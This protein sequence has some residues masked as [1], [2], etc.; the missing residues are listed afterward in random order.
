MTNNAF[1]LIA[2]LS[3]DRQPA[4]GRSKLYRG[5]SMSSY[6]FYV[7]PEIVFIHLVSKVITVQILT[8]KVGERVNWLPINTEETKSMVLI[9]LFPGLVHS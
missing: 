6:R 4:I 1:G 8:F 5:K 3:L 9:L 2:A 7:H